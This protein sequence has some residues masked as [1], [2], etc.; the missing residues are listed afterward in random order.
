MAITNEFYKNINFLNTIY[1]TDLAMKQHLADLLFD[2]DSSRIIYSSNAYAFRKR[3]DKNDGNL[4]LPFVN[5]YLRGYDP[6]VRSR[7]NVAMY[8][9]GIFIP[10]LQQKVRYAP[11]TLDYEAS[12]WSHTDIDNKY[13]FSEFVWDTD[14][15][16]IL[17]PSVELL[18]HEIDFPAHL[19]YT[20]LD[21]NPEYNEQDWLERNKIHSSSIDFEL[22][23]LAIKSND[24]INIPERVLFNFI[25]TQGE[26]AGTVE[27]AYEYLVSELSEE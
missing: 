6:G 12:F 3:A 24:V 20:G 25:H 26:N 27:E 2:G 11:I 18:G 17:K 1:A 10:E 5:F 4:N 21:L 22:E 16:T 7:W 23:T 9:K 8:S 14:N 15:K 19:G 13:A